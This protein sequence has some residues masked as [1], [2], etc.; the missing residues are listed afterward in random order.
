MVKHGS[1]FVGRLGFIYIVPVVFLGIDGY[2]FHPE[3]A[4]ALNAQQLT[5]WLSSLINAGWKLKIWQGNLFKEHF[6][7]ANN[8]KWNEVFKHVL[9]LSSGVW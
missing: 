5:V 1:A 7:R 8:M 6:K 2:I 4:S 9:S 3:C